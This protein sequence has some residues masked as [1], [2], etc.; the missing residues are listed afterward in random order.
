MNLKKKGMKVGERPIYFLSLYLI[1]GPSQNQL[2]KNSC[3][4]LK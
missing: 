2:L 4:F 1:F 3:K